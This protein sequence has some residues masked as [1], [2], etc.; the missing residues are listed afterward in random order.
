M[1]QREIF[2]NVHGQDGQGITVFSAFIA[3][4]LAYHLFVPQDIKNYLKPSFLSASRPTVTAN[5]CNTA[6]SGSAAYSTC[7]YEKK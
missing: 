1:E 5:N 4:A 3:A 6:P 7:M 2:R